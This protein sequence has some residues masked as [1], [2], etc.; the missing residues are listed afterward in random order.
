MKVVP[1]I[2]RKT[3][4]AVILQ[5]GFLASSLNGQNWQQIGI[6]T[7]NYGP[8]RLYADTFSDNIYASG[9]FTFYGS[10]P[11]NN[12]AKWDGIN[13]TPLGTEISS[14][15]NSFL[16]WNNEIYSCP[17]VWNNK[18]YVAKWNGLTWDSIGRAMGP[19]SLSNLVSYGNDLMVTGQFSSIDGVPANSI[20]LWNGIAW[21]GLPGN[22]MVWNGSVITALVFNGELYIGGMF[23]NNGFNR[24]AKWNGSSWIQV[25]N[26]FTGGFGDVVELIEYNNELYA[27]GAFTYPGP[28]NY[29]AKWNGTYWE[30]VGGGVAGTT[31]VDGQIKDAV[32]FNNKL[33]VCGDFITAGGITVNYLASWDGTNWC[34][35]GGLN[36]PVSA[37]TLM[38]NE[39]YISG[40]FYYLTPD[41]V[42]FVAKWT[43][44]NFVDTC[45]N[46]TG[47]SEI[48]SESDITVYPNPS[49][50]VFNLH[51]SSDI[52]LL[53]VVDM[54][55]RVVMSITNIGSPDYILDLTGQAD[56]LYFLKIH[57]DAGI[58]SR[59]IV[60][61]R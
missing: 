2:K 53:E 48:I 24:V 17:I 30:D 42:I 50:G 32:V 59:R 37:M 29:I 3:L 18:Y 6:D 61:A 51:G 12:R 22:T 5:T 4:F 25:G 20:A 14:S 31:P 23:T 44:G 16:R 9:S 11:F 26:G 39:L 1:D 35:Y 27:V 60:L 36:N 19:G 41:T 21:S 52:R 57:T 40:G 10:A 49:A 7:F 34:G 47:I 54:Q 58:A 38:N 43:G 28:S 55:G 45:A 33:F 56:G 46:T 15:S 13:W 8:T